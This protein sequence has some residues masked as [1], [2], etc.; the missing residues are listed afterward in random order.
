MNFKSLL[1]ILCI[2]M[3]FSCKEAKL[4]LTKIEG[5]RIL[6]SDSLS[7]D[8]EI[9]NFVK[10]YRDHIKKD[11]DSV[12]SY[13]A[14][15]YSK[16]DG[17]FNTAIGN[18]MA[19]AIY[20]EANPIFKSRTGKDIDIVLL[21]FDG[22]RSDISKGNITTKTA[23]ELMPF[24]NSLVVVALKGSQMALLIDYLRKGKKAHPI[25]KLKL[26]IDKDFN[27]VK[28]TIN[29]K[30]IEPNKTYFV[31][32]HDYLYYGGDN[33]TFFIPNDSLYVL[34]YKV[35]NAFIDHFKKVDTIKP[36]MDDR[37]IQTK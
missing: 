31:A 5:K 30:K 34:D 7:F 1:S 33:M 8:Q 17:E 12:L 10:P 36:V 16:S 11:L 23:F 21:N 3:T 29:N 24:E 37:F 15:H 14:A 20:E 2:L 25:S 28:T 6:I 22:I 13:S 4:N 35:R 26:E 27:V 9:D 19:D 18:F 32:T